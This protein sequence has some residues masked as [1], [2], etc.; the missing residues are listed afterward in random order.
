MLFLS[1]EWVID[2]R[3]ITLTNRLG[4]VCSGR[5]EFKPA[6]SKLLY[7]GH[8]LPPVFCGLVFDKELACCLI[9]ATC[10]HQIVDSMFVS[11][12]PVLKQHSLDLLGFFEVF[13]S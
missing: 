8:P 4:L 9:K 7:V 10:K 13:V 1:L 3:L 6:P 5:S 11:M 12:G 2:I